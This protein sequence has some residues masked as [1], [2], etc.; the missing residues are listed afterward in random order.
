MTNYFDKQKSQTIKQIRNLY[1]NRDATFR[2]FRHNYG[3]GPTGKTHNSTDAANPN[4]TDAATP[5]DILLIKKDKKSNGKKLRNWE[6]SFSGDG[7]RFS[8]DASDNKSNAN[9][10]DKFEKYLKKKAAT[11]ELK[12]AAQEL[13]KAKSLV[14]N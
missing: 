1:D 9:G 13:K 11:A 2:G 10:L 12:A 6:N 5:S 4:A 14:K 7:D 3:A 8:E